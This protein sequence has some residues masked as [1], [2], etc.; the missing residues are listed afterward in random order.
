MIEKFGRSEQF[1]MEAL[2]SEA[3]ANTHLELEGVDEFLRHFSHR[4]LTL[5][6]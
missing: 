3:L 2:V 1:R 5:K 6:R 4:F